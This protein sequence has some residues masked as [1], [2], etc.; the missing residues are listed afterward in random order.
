MDFPRF[1]KEN[2]Q[3]F[4]GDVIYELTQKPEIS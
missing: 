2:K 4:L 1:L 3:N